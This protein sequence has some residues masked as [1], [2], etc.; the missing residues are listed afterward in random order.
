MDGIEQK[1]ASNYKQWFLI[2]IVAGLILIVISGGVWVYQKTVKNKPPATDQITP[3]PI[4][5]E[6]TITPEAEVTPGEVTTTPSAKEEL[7]I[8]IL[9][10][11]GVKGEAGRAALLLGKAGFKNI[12]TGN[13]ARFDYE[14]TEISIKEGEKEFLQD[15]TEALA[16]NYTVSSDSKTLEAKDTYDVVIILGKNKGGE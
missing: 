5:E 15:L 1:S 3:T 4:R 2:A 14:Q 7:K 13:A 8:Q 12:K 10:G 9:N 16:E 11:G 6:T